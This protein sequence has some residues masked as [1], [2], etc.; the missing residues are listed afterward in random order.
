MKPG[1][2]RRNDKESHGGNKYEQ[3]QERSKGTPPDPA[4]GLYIGTRRDACDEQGHNE[5]DNRHANGVHPKNADRL[6][7]TDEL[8]ERRCGM[9]KN[10]KASGESE[11][12]RQKDACSQ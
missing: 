5:G 12:Q 3:P 11:N 10:N 8:Q 6:D 4:N 2:E 9:R 7:E 1:K